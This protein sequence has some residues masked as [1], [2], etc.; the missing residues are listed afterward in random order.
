M[1]PWTTAT[2]ARGITALAASTGT[3]GEDVAC[4]GESGG[5]STPPRTDQERTQTLLRDAVDHRSAPLDRLPISTAA[6]SRV[7]EL[8]ATQRFE[9]G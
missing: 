1:P 7:H 3:Y 5:S 8:P 4:R 9:L 2:W 6:E